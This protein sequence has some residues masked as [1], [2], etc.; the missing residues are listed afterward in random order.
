MK[1]IFTLSLMI[2]SLQ[3]FAQEKIKLSGYFKEDYRRIEISKQL[4]R[5]IFVKTKG[6][7][8]IPK[9]ASYLNLIPADAKRLGLKDIL[10]ISKNGEDYEKS[11]TAL[12]TINAVQISDLE[13]GLFLDFSKT[14]NADDKLISI[15]KNPQKTDTLSYNLFYNT[16]DFSLTKQW[17]D[18]TDNTAEVTLASTMV[19][20]LTYGGSES[21]PIY[22]LIPVNELA[23]KALHY[24]GNLFDLGDTEEWARSQWQ[25]WYQETLEEKP[26]E[27]LASSATTFTIPDNYKPD[28]YNRAL[29]GTDAVSKKILAIESLSSNVDDFKG[30]QI[31]KWDSANVH[32]SDYYRANQKQLFKIDAFKSLGSDL[33]VIGKYNTWTQLRYDEITQQYNIQKQLMI[34]LPEKFKVTGENNIEIVQMGENLSYVVLKNKLAGSFFILTINTVTGEVLFAKKLTELLPNVDEKSLNFVYLQYGTEITDGFLFGVR[35]DKQYHLVKTSIDLTKA[36]AIET[37]SIIQNSTAFMRAD[38]LDIM[39]LQDGF[40]R[41][42]SFNS[43]I[44]TQ[45]SEIGVTEFDQNYYDKDGAITYDGENY[46]VFFSYDSPL[47]S[48]IKMYTLNM[49]MKPINAKNI[50]NFLDIEEPMEHNLVHLLYASKVKNHV[51]LFFKKGEKLHYTKI[52]DTSIEQ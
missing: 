24:V 39:N 4:Q 9:A 20:H 19:A 23:R 36:N 7:V 33:F 47:K 30:H 31:I 41:Y 45:K 1:I 29:F 48:G 12:Q 13:Q 11:N 28:D 32:N 38:E 42:L 25:K 49:H 15:L 26:V 14:K 22:N 27:M 46:H 44:N 21:S 51:W 52:M 35:N 50:F 18:V 3:T 40:L 2:F 16:N 10:V 17:I 8:V 6:N 34:E 5:V 37:T 43:S